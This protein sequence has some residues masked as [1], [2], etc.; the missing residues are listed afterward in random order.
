[1][2]TPKPE[3]ATLFAALSAFIARGEA[4]ARKDDTSEE[5]GKQGG[6]A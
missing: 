1:M 2:I 6:E 4:G 3:R 5:T